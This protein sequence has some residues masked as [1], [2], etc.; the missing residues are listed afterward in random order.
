M[1]YHT[2]KHLEPLAQYLT[3][4]GVSRIEDLA[5][6]AGHPPQDDPQVWVGAI[7]VGKDIYSANSANRDLYR[8]LVGLASQPRP[9]PLGQPS[10]LPTIDNH[11]FI[12]LLPT[13]LFSKAIMSIIVH[14]RMLRLKRGILMQKPNS[15][16]RT[17]WH[18][19]SL[20]AFCREDARIRAGDVD[21]TK[22][23]AG[24]YAEFRADWNNDGTCQYKFSAFDRATGTST[25]SGKEIPIEKLAPI[26]MHEEEECHSH[27]RT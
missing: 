22:P 16:E 10:S 26:N 2:V 23:E 8:Q 25:V 18:D 15:E 1:P 21:L 3:A 9:H 27:L 14:P 12:T 6:G 5:E 19:E 4:H 24:G 13:R 11:S 17:F 7:S 20:R